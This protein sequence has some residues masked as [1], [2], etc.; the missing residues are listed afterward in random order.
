[1]LINNAIGHML[2][3]IFN[4]KMIGK[5]KIKPDMGRK[6]N[7]APKFSSPNLCLLMI[8][9]FIPIAISTIP[10]IPVI[11]QQLWFFLAHILLN[12]RIMN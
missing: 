2:Q 8:V 3:A 6:L 11:L 9:G 5:N 4:V 12:F 1:M 7:R 10:Y